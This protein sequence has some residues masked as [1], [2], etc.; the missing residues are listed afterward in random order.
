MSNPITPYSPVYFGTAYSPD[1]FGAVVPL[2]NHSGLT[3]EIAAYIPTIDVDAVG[4]RHYLHD[5]FD[6]NAAVNW[7]AEWVADT[8]S[9]GDWAL[10]F[11]Q[12]QNDIVDLKS[13]VWADAEPNFSFSVWVRY[14]LAATMTIY[15]QTDGVADFN[16]RVF[17]G[18]GA[19]GYSNGTIT[20][21]GSTSINDGQWHHIAVSVESTG[22][23]VIYIDGVE[24]VRQAFA[25]YTGSATNT[26]S[27]G[28]IRYGDLFDSTFM[29]K[30]DAVRFFNVAI[31]QATVTEIFGQGRR[32]QPAGSAFTINGQASVDFVA[33]LASRF[34]IEGA[35]ST[36]FLAGA[37]QPADFAIVGAAT[38]NFVGQ[39][40]SVFAIEGQ[41]DVD[42]IADVGAS[43]FDIRGQASVAFVSEPP[44]ANFAIEGTAS[45]AFISELPASAFAIEGVATVQFFTDLIPANRI[46]IRSASLNV[47]RAPATLNVPRAPA[48]LDTF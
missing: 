39:P 13:T 3:G 16:H 24:D 2:P 8:D 7:G 29:G 22:D 15:A 40:A 44:S 38:V 42:F 45:V 6:A 25:A 43:F 47:V 11:T 27:I 5:L 18:F 33:E 32:S 12:T 14:T 30:I 41:A 48:T 26:A 21:G 17:T 20:V 46:T 28:S 37:E 34:D 35:A 19:I 10:D 4:S 9:G 1:Y 31:S 36:S 23:V